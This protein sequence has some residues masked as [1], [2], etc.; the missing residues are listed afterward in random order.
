MLEYSFP[1]LFVPWTVH[2]LELSFPKRINTA[3]PFVPWNGPGNEC[4]RERIILRTN[5]PDT[6]K[7]Y[8][9]NINQTGTYRNSDTRYSDTRYP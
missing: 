6:H 1:R 3:G 2:A 8:D 4:S 7:R 9:T 5:I